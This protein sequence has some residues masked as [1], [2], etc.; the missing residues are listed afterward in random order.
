[1]DKNN[2]LNTLFMQDKIRSSIATLLSSTFFPWFRKE[3]KEVLQRSY[4]LIESNHASALAFFE[5]LDV[6]P[7][8]PSV[9]VN[10]ISKLFSKIVTPWIRKRDNT[11]ESDEDKDDARPAKRSKNSGTSGSEYGGQPQYNKLIQFSLR[12]DHCIER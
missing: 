7:I 9:I 3:L 10:F 2:T 11:Q 6:K 1:M 8:P 4:S 12:F 5:H